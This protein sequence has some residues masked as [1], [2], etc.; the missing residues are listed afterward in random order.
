MSAAAAASPAVGLRR[1]DRATPSA[2]QARESLVL[3]GLA[4][5]ALAGLGAGEWGALLA[6]PPTGR[7]AIVVVVAMAGGLTL[8]STARLRGPAVLRTIA[9]IA[10]VAILAG[11]ALAVTGLAARLLLPSHWPAL[12][13]DLHRGLSGASNTSWPYEGGDPWVRLTLA[14]GVPVLVVPAA[15]MA[16]YPARRLAGLLR[17]AALV[18]LLVLYTLPATEAGS[19]SPIGRGA[20]LL[21]L[22]SAWLWLPRLRGREAIPAAAVL[23]VS[24]AAAVPVAT[25]LR[26]HVAWIDYSNW[27][28]AGGTGDGRSF[29]WDQR[30]GPLPWSRDGLTMLSVRSPRSHYWKAETL[31]RFDGLRWI[32]SNAGV[33]SDPSSEV[34]NAR[35]RRWD[36]S[37]RFTVRNL[38]SDVLVGA[39]TVYSVDTQKLLAGSAD[40]TIRVIDG[41][42]ANGDTYTVR[43]YVPDPSAAQMRAAP[44]EFPTQF[45]PYTYVTLPGPRD[46]ALTAGPPN[47]DAPAVG[48][49]TVSS[50]RPGASP[51]DD[52]ATRRLILASPYASTYRLARSLAAGH[53][54]QYDVVQSVQRYLQR[55]FTYDEHP[56]LRRYPLPAFLFRDRVGYC[57]QFSG[58]MALLLRLDGIPAR[59]AAGFAPGL[60]D[61][62]T[63]DYRV[64][65]LDAHSWVEVWF[66][67]IGWVPFD[68]TP[69]L[70]PASAQAT[71]SNAPSAALG[72]RDTGAGGSARQRATGGAS[73]GASAGRRG[74]GLGAILVL[75]AAAA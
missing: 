7:L 54:T 53:R 16:F 10:L 25:A 6:G 37:I 35:D 28:I 50:P 39:G 49:R 23:A 1:N 52:P 20:I 11:V 56:P 38:R 17:A 64:R 8:A 61:P 31:D 46:S 19:G 66:S 60:R 44:R 70:A 32:H 4:F 26:G 51:G 40:G 34:P 13:A 47:P 29:D 33:G 45:L 5:A 41:P 2:A 15:V 43:A 36:E 75:A 55:G 68:P 57:Q 30:Y 58:A 72:G 42:L 48:P 24:A 69:S 21:V 71:G 67:G 9:R 74:S 65:D 63:R 22:V 3:R 59:V 73:T 12:A 18:A 27:R 14:L 62:H